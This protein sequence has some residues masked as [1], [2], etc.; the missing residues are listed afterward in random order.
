MFGNLF[1]GIQIGVQNQPRTFASLPTVTDPDKVLAD[2][3]TSDYDRFQMDFRP[4]EQELVNQLNS[5]RQD[6]VEAVP[7]DVAQQQRIAEGISERNRQRFGVE[8]TQA[9]Q[10]GRIG[11]TQRGAALN[12]AGGLNNARLAQLDQ[13]RVLLADLI[14]I[15]QGLNRSS[16]QNLGT[17]AENMTAR[18]NQFTQDKA[19]ARN[20]RISLIGS[21]AGL[22]IFSLS[23]IHI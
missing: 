3:S 19:A 17:A 9:Q 14:N 11:A 5:G 23:L 8:E 6:L 7:D 22:A 21:L 12:L 10:R 16:I 15:G 1:R 20:Q 2:V 13:Y 4:F 18:K